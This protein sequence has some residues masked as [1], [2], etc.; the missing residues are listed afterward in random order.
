ML[1]GT[2]TNISAPTFR[3][4]FE[5]RQLWGF[6]WGPLIQLGASRHMSIQ[7]ATTAEL[8]EP[9]WVAELLLS[10]QQLG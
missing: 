2:L 1:F 6:L 10:V 5:D 8:F 7:P 3:A 9:E 4:E